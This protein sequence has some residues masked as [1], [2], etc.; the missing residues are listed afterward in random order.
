MDSSD[1]RERR[2]FASEV[3]FVVPRVTGLAVMDW[4]RRELERDPHGAGSHGDQYHTSTIYFDSAAYDVFHRRRSFGRC[5]YRIR[6][7]EGQGSVFLERKLRRPGLLAKRRTIVTAS[8]L[9]HLEQSGLNGWAGNWFHRRLLLR[10]LQPVCELGYTRV[11]RAGT[12]PSGPIRL[13]LDDALHVAPTRRPLFGH[14]GQPIPMMEGSMILELKF[15]VEVPALFK[16]LAEEFR[17]VPQTASKYRIGIAAL[18]PGG[19]R[20]EAVPVSAVVVGPVGG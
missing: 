19:T 17:L 12:S 16:R 11:A 8:A 3:K 4:A 15:R 13:T 7:Y 14:A 1:A 6:R 10:G 18:D 5:K 2:V 9:S 20:G